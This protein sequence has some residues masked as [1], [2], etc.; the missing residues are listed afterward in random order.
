MEDDTPKEK[1]KAKKKKDPNAPKKPQSGC[2]YCA[3]PSHVHVFRLR[4]EHLLHTPPVQLSALR[5]CSPP[6][7][8][9]NRWVF[10]NTE[11]RDEVKEAN[12]DATFADLSKLIGAK[13]SALSDDDKLPYETKAREAKAQYKVDI[14]KYYEENPDAKAEYAS[15]AKAKK[16]KTADGP[17]KP[18]SS[19]MY[20]SAAKR[21]EVKV[22]VVFVAF[23][24]WKSELGCC[25]S[26]WWAGITRYVMLMCRVCIYVD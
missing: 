1:K 15:P 4:L 17:K 9:P 22:C 19:Y 7:G 14:E 6:C 23:E 26:V 25:P 13:W 5:G 3:P 16:R 2:V 12:P 21:D 10:F 18:A 24:Y 11:V 8:A 20:F